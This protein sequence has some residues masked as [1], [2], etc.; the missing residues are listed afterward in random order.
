VVPLTLTALASAR[1][2]P[3]TR[4]LKSRPALP[5]VDRFV[6]RRAIL[7]HFI[8][9]PGHRL[10]KGEG[11]VRFAVQRKIAYFDVYHLRFLTACIGPTL[12]VMLGRLSELYFDRVMRRKPWRLASGAERQDYRQSLYAR[13]RSVGRLIWKSKP[14]G[15]GTLPVT[16]VSFSSRMCA[17]SLTPK[18]FFHRAHPCCYGRLQG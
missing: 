10:T 1:R 14:R 3:R 9:A 15:I 18:S 17:G 2:I 7:P 8:I 11:E 12:R 4:F 13:E 5:T 6:D 16:T